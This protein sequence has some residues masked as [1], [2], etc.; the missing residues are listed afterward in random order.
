MMTKNSRYKAALLESD[1]QVYQCGQIPSSIEMEE[2]ARLE[3][4]STE[5]RRRGS[6]FVVVVKGDVHQ[7]PNISD[8]QPISTPAVVWFDRKGRFVRTTNRMYVL[9]QPGDNEGI[10]A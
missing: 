5:V 7:H 3:N 2:S 10:D 8:G 1:I 6:E 9:G 4:W